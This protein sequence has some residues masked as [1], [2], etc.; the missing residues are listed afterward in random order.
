MQYQQKIA[1]D[2]VFRHDFIQNKQTDICLCQQ[3]IVNPNNLT[4]VKQE[5]IDGLSGHDWPTNK[6]DLLIVVLEMTKQQV[7]ERNVM[8]TTRC[9]KNLHSFLCWLNVE[10]DVN[11]MRTN[12]IQPN[13]S[14]T[15]MLLP[16]STSSNT[17]SRHALSGDSDGLCW[18]RP[19]RRWH[20]RLLG[21][22]SQQTQ[23][24][25]CWQL[26]L[27]PLISTTSGPVRLKTKLKLSI[28][29][30]ST[31]GRDLCLDIVVTGDSET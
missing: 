29:S 27:G 20:S 28:H 23:R 16:F 1:N 14:T 19:F 3:F 26:R 9:E 12:L 31:L 2:E 7:C 11:S 10:L 4:Y 22:H 18:R 30:R 5:A 25:H 17:D 6:R 15:V 13:L 24:P 21:H 8:L